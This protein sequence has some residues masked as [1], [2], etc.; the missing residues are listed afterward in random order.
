MK[1]KLLLLSFLVFSICV[2]AQKY[3][4]GTVVGDSGQSI[5]GAMVLNT[6][7]D[8]KT[9]SDKEGNFIIPAA[10][11]DE[12]RFIA[13]GFDRVS[14]KVSEENFQAA[15]KVTLLRSVTTIPEVEIA[16][17]AT[18]DLKRDSKALDL[19]SRVVALNSTLRGSMRT[20]LKE[21]LPQNSVPSSF[22]P[23]KIGQGQIN[24]FKVA[25]ALAGIAKKASEPS[26]TTPTYAETEQFL[27]KLKANTNWEPYRI[28][29]GW[30]D[31]QID[32]FLLYANDTQYLAK[33]Y[34]NNFNKKE[35]EMYLN[36]ALVDFL[37]LQKK[38]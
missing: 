23:P 31:E 19:S 17:R 5:P 32:K 6:R 35:I 22:G 8:E 2:S 20:P 25:A 26:K 7:T 36:A 1:I 11:A 34:R 18:G 38:S 16:F 13:S 27:A 15:L 9:F 4:I 3:L 24:L 28:Q 29:Y 14:I 33:N 37:K 21:P 30:D 10:A 12:V